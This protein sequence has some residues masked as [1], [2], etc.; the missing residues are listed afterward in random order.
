V[1]DQ[2]SDGSL[3]RRKIRLTEEAKL[4]GVCL[5]SFDPKPEFPAV[6]SQTPAAGIKRPRV[7]TELNLDWTDG[8]RQDLMTLCGLLED[9]H[10]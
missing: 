4:N 2:H 10:G 7:L 3:E 9:L 8:P 6:N 5:L 1:T